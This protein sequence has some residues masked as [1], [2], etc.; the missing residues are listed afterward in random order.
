MNRPGLRRYAAARFAVLAA[1]FTLASCA[2]APDLTG[3]SDTVEASRPLVVATSSIVADFVGQVAGANVRVE[4][5]VPNGFDTHTYEP[6]PSELALLSEAA[7][8]VFADTSLNANITGIVRLSGAEDRILDLN[9]TALD[10]DDYVYPEDGGA[11]S[12]N[13]HTW[14]SPA[15]AAKW[16]TPLAERIVELAP[17]AVDEIDANA[18]Q[19]RDEL[20]ALDTEIR[21]TLAAVPADRRKLVVYHDAWEYFGREYG[22]TVIGAIQAV[23]FAEPS[24][25]KLAEMAAQIRSEGV[26]VFFGSEVFPSGVLEALET[27]SGAQYIPDLADDRLPGRPGDGNHTYTA[28]MRANLTLLMQGLGR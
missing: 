11:A 12:A 19:F 1:A 7:L 27:E 22:L 5:L 2:S 25:Q 4:T 23:N 14:T 17:D 9:A 26:D 13:P 6:K 20:A 24:A 16:V 21:D 3:G 18:A 8:I 28:L 15:L 10:P